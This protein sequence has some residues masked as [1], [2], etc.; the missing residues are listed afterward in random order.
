MVRHGE[1]HA[2]HVA[3]DAPGRSIVRVI[4]SLAKSGME[5]RAGHGDT[6]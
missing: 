2:I 5:K 3:P 6:R 1:S 4:G